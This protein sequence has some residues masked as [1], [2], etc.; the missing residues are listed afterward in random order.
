MYQYPPIVPGTAVGPAPD[1]KGTQADAPTS[2]HPPQ[3]SSHNSNN[4][5]AEIHVGTQAETTR[6]Q[7]G[8][9]KEVSQAR[10]ARA[11]MIAEGPKPPPLNWKLAIDRLSSAVQQMERAIDVVETSSSNFIKPAAPLA[12]YPSEDAMRKADRLSAFYKSTEADAAGLHGPSANEGSARAAGGQAAP[13]A[14]VIRAEKR[15]ADA[16]LVKAQNATAQSAPPSGDGAGK[17]TG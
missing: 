9:Y 15:A 17:Q 12:I 2:S 14:F 16:Q 1:K 3:N 4:A 7:S 13:N 10:R 8:I 5:A 11:Q 6:S